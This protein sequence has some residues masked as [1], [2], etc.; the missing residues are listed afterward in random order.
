V[1]IAPSNIRRCPE[2]R[3]PA[4]LLVAWLSLGAAGCHRGDPAST[5]RGAH[6]VP[7]TVARVIQK[8]MPV[9]V[10]AV[11]NVEHY[12]VVS[13]A[14]QVSGQV[15]RVHFKEGDNVK[16]GDLLFTLDRRPFL[17]ALREANAKRERD[18]VL[19]ANAK[20]DLER[21]HGL[22]A[23]GYVS[24]EQFDKTRATAEAAQAT[25]RAERSAVE[26]AKLEL[27]YATIRSPI[28]GRTGSLLVNE[29]NVVKAND[30]PLLVIRQV[31]PIYVRFTVPEQVVS[32]IRARYAAS[33]IAVEV[34]PRDH[35][36]PPARGELTFIENYV[37][38]SSGTIG[39]KAV[40]P[41]TDEALWPG[42]YVDVVL[43]LRTEAN[44]V[45]AP[46]AA[47]QQT[48]EGQAVFVLRPDKTVTLRKVTVVRTIDEEAVIGK[49]LSPAEMVVTDGQL[50]LT[51]G[52]RVEVKSTEPA[53][54]A[55]HAG[56]V[57]APAWLAG[58]AGSVQARRRRRRTRD[59]EHLGALHPP[60][61]RHHPGDALR[62]AVRGDVVPRA[63]G[64]RAT[65]RG[66]PDH[67]GLGGVA[68]GRSRDHGLVG[69]H[70]PGTRVLGHRRR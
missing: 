10:A 45:V 11:G 59:D 20:R 23:K 39:L 60:S 18:E 2:R 25:L 65:Q 9:N 13:V 36:G 63:A 68:R 1:S 46:A 21:Y 19:A 40:F 50:Q 44:A 58:P 14:P 43:K 67:H 42:Q 4:L 24:R 70:T 48:R 8:T 41:N 27:Q 17:A 26:T 6:P 56:A 32:I 55:S 29:G 34:A 49:G 33:K 7:V 38:V 37:D 3:P 69:G 22:V 5:G 52:S 61:R 57:V 15:Q 28:D 66:L 53:G 35:A 54:P 47:I 16:R 12:A 31:R 64:E 30:K 51:D 62:R